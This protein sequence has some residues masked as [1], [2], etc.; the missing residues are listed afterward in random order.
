[1]LFIEERNIIELLEKEGYNA[2]ECINY[3]NFILPSNYNQY[4]NYLAYKLLTIDI[5][6]IEPFLSYQSVLFLGN[7]YAVKDNFIGLLEFLVYDI[8][9]KRVLPNEQVRL[10]KI[11]N[12]LER[13][14]FFLLSKAYNDLGMDDETEQTIQSE[15]LTSPQRKIKMDPHF[16]GVLCEKLN[17]F[18]EG[19]DQAL[20]N[21]I[22][23]NEFSS[24]LP[25]Y[26]QANQLAE[27]F[28]RLR[29][30]EK[31]TVSTNK[32]LADWLVNSFCTIDDNGK[33]SPL[34]SSTVEGVLKNSDREPPK[35]KRILIELAQY[36]QPDKR[37]IDKN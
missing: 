21:L 5:Y 6:K 26:G 11:V 12:W 24:L 22:I 18:F 14:R 1:M 30:N 27:L 32:L 19:H 36:I 33:P 29:Y 2:K 3:R 34:L 9:Q 28:K 7:D 23:K 31:I 17:Y 16:A 15:T 20:Y 13:N 8:V 35:T 25:F 10:E 4:N 37:K